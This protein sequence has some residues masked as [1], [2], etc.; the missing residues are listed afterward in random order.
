MCAIIRTMPKRVRDKEIIEA[1]D[2]ILQKRIFIDS[3]KK[4]HREVLSILTK[5]GNETGVSAER[6]RIIG[7]NS[8]KIKIDI[9]TRSV[10]EVPETETGYLRKRKIEYDGD[11]DRWRRTGRGTDRKGR[12]YKKGEFASVGQ[13]CPVCRNLLER[14]ENKTLFGGKAMIGFKC[15][16]CKYITGRRWREPAKYTFSRKK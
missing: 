10:D 11:V 9:K 12:E 6:M 3:Q 13:P 2:Q 7:I 16:V 14:M 1:I 15:R 8:G 4:L 5:N